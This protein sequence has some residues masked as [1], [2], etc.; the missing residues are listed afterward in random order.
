M[1]P[2]NGLGGSDGRGP[3]SV[4]GRR[5]SGEL[6]VIYESETGEPVVLCTCVWLSRSGGYLKGG[7]DRRLA[8]ASVSR[9]L[10][11][12]EE[13]LFVKFFVGSHLDFCDIYAGKPAWGTDQTLL[14]RDGMLLLV[15][16]QAVHPTTGRINMSVSELAR[17]CG[18][19]LSAISVSISRLK[20]ARLVVN[21]R[22][23]E[24]GGLY[25]L[26][27]PG[28]VAVGSE[29]GGKRKKL[30]Q[31]FYAVLEEELSPRAKEAIAS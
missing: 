5:A 20:K 16:M 23:K 26:L 15:L 10:K 3:L 8:L 19:P 21:S 9:R 22:C 29:I 27:N 2:Q 6:I 7:M 28:L 13:D 12:E 31:N 1:R 18:K 17:K 25:M 30:Y 14:P 4:E 11:V 24:T